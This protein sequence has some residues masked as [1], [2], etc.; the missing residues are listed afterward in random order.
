M[1]Y[2]YTLLF[3]FALFF[4]LKTTQA[5][6]FN[7]HGTVY[8]YFNKKPVEAVTVYTSSGQTTFTDS[9]G[10]YIIKVKNTDSIWFSYLNKNT[11]KYSVDTILD[12]LHFEIALYIDIAWLPKVTVYGKNYT[13]D[14]I[15]NRKEYAKIFNF[16]K[17]TLQLN[18]ISPSNYIPGGVTVGLDLDALINMFK[19][20]KNREMEKLKER[21]LQQE[22]DK[23]IDHRFTKLFVRRL[24]HLEGEK[25]LTFMI[26][27]RPNYHQLIKMN[28][29]ELGYYIEQCYKQDLYLNKL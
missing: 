17:P 24:T 29:L 26:Y 4:N 11:I 6:Q 14:S 8:N 25:L 21:L 13:L 18:S 15:N 22:R 10:K 20:R 27:Y 9:V 2:R 23:Y 12:P 28:D 16:K 7:L 1:K 3:S 19:F 5:Q